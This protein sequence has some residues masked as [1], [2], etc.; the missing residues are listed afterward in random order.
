MNLS[1]AADDVKLYLGHVLEVLEGFPEECFHCVV[2]S[3]PYWSLRDYKLPPVAWPGGWFSPMPGVPEMEMDEWRGSLGM[4]PM[5]ELYVFHLVLVFRAVWQVL[6]PDG[7]VWLNL[8]DTYMGS[9]HGWGKE[10]TDRSWRRRHLDDRGRGRAP[11]AVYNRRDLK[12]KDMVCVP[13]RVGLALQADGWWLRQ[14]VIWAKGLSFCPVYSGSSMPESVKDRPAK[15]HE[16]LLILTKRRR[17]FYDNEAVKER[18][19]RS[20][21]VERLDTEKRFGGKAIPG[22]RKAARSGRVYRYTGKR[23]LRSVWT[24]GT[25]PFGGAHFAAFPPGLVEPCIKAG[26]SDRG[27]C[28]ECG[29]PWER[30]VEKTGPCRVGKAGPKDVARE[31]QLLQSDKTGL[32][33]AGWRRNKRGRSGT[34][35]WRPTCSCYGD[36]GS[37]MIGCSRCRGSGRQTV[38]GRN[39][40]P[41]LNSGYR[42]HSGDIRCHPVM[43]IDEPCAKC[44]GTGTVVVPVGK[45]GWPTVPCV[46]LDPFCGT[47]VAGEVAIKLGRRF[48]GI[49]LNPSYC[50]MA[51]E[52]LSGPIQ[53]AMPGLREPDDEGPPDPVQ[54]RML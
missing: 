39:P 43:V 15:S 11:S 13:W 26:T 3:P 38:E 1:W 6:R 14:D 16:Y 37:A 32:G 8:G 41:L 50:R 49:D 22:D 44:G 25:R 28:P 18:G 5:P 48:V 40:D 7:V 27:C 20:A 17:Y 21:Y 19:R 42:T 36:L 34:V 52:R 35:G 54:L 29:A 10:D 33:G 24:I 23:N 51:E 45:V 47:G 9:G 31:L 46:V 30:V 2:T 53:L 12:P 4:E